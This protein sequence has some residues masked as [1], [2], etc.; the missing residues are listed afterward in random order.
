MTGALFQVSPFH[1]FI[2]CVVT[3]VLMGVLT[4]VIYRAFAKIDRRG[5]VS[6]LAGSLSAPL[7]NT[8]FFMGYICLVFWHTDY[9]QNLASG[10]G[11][12]NP[13][14][15]VVLLVG[16]QGLIEAATCGVLGTVITKALRAALGFRRAAVRV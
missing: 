14:M 6:A 9:V 1:T 15:F 2:L 16:V 11:A 13:L 5:F 7:L 3:R 10:L 12:A 8:F 4:G